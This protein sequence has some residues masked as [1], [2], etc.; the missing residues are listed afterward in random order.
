MAP[1]WTAH[2]GAREEPWIG[3]GRTD[4]PITEATSTGQGGT[5][6]MP[7]RHHGRSMSPLWWVHD[8]STMG[9]WCVHGSSM[10][11][12]NRLLV[13]GVSVV[14][15]WWI[16]G[17]MIGTWRLS[18]PC[19]VPPRRVAPWWIHGANMVGPCLPMGAWWVNGVSMMSSEGK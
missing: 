7:W 19:M 2:G 1:P 5:K 18:G 12:R 10:W 9:P 17:G 6:G 11:V 13:H 4:G 3:H 15:P 16:H 8:V 14:G